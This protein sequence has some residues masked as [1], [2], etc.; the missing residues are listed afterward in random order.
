VY[1]QRGEAAVGMIVGLSEFLRRASE[2]S[3]RTVT[4]REEVEYLHAYIDIQK[5]RF[6]TP[7]SERHIPEDLMATQVPT[8]LAAA[9]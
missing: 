8:L 5:V 7:A 4:L 6:A 1:D 9:C 2:D 3:H